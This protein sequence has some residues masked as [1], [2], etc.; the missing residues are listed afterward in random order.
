VGG[1]RR[2]VEPAHAFLQGAGR[3]T[4]QAVELHLRNATAWANDRTGENLAE[5]IDPESL[6]GNLRR[7]HYELGVNAPPALRLT[8]AFHELAQAI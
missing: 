7:G 8:A 1:G 4:S 3:V 6:L 2:V 5:Q